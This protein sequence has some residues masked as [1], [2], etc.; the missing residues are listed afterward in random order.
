MKASRSFVKQCE[1][2]QQ[3]LSLNWQLKTV[4]NLIAKYSTI[5]EL[6]ISS[7]GVRTWTIWHSR[8]D[9]SCRRTASISR[10][11][12]DWR[13]TVYLTGRKS[14]AKR[15]S[16]G[17]R[18]RESLNS[19]SFTRVNHPSDAFS[20]AGSDVADVYLSAFFRT[21]ES[22]HGQRWTRTRAR[23]WTW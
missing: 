19:S 21:I 20:I 7:S 6:Y 23:Q 16:S 18:P 17:R 22:N 8:L 11:P 4:W 9:D 2:L 12:G 3:S 10:A 13:E 14:S 5:I 1:E 15:E